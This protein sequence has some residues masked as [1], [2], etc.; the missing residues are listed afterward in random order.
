MRLRKEA[1][2][3]ARAGHMVDVVCLRDHP[4]QAPQ[5]RIDGVN[6]YRLP[7]EHQRRGKLHYLYEYLG[8]FVLL[9]LALIWLHLRRRYDVIVTTNMP[10]LTT[11]AAALPKLLGARVVFDLHECMPE[12]FMVKY[13]IG[14]RHPVVRLLSAMEQAAIAFAD[15]AITCTEEMKRIFVARGAPADKFA[16]FLNT[17]NE[18]IFRPL[19]AASPPAP[20]TFTLMTHGSIEERYGHA[21]A[22]RA[23]ALLRAHIP[24][25][26]FEI[27]GDGTARQRVEQL[28]RELGVDDIVCFHGYVSFEDLVR[29][30]NR[31]D[32]G[33]VTIEQ[34]P[35]MR[36]VH[37]LKMFDYLAVGKP[38]VISRLRAVED[39][40]DDTCLTYFDHNSP[41]ALA[42]A[43]LMLYRNPE[44][45]QNRVRNASKVYETLRWPVQA[46]EFVALIERI[47]AWK[48]MHTFRRSV[49]P[50]K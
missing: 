9:S 42:E 36:W 21:T 24:G 33:V 1:E 34:R 23:V 27:F 47:A 12:I 44:L 11:F 32:I 6:V 13:G 38:V 30:I 45:R 25:L 18:A 50:A 48:N 31:A 49:R 19:E 35:E 5:E 40:F 16:V 39:Y 7:M 26:R 46:V 2:A 10:D 41:E 22:I 20:D 4:R 37:T 3:L 15:Y 14:P 17:S 29:A 28:T 43:V 8:G